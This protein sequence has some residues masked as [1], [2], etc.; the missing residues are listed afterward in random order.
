MP[1]INGTY[2]TRL[3]A[4][5]EESDK[6]LDDFRKARKRFVKEYSGSHYAAGR[7]VVLNLVWQQVRAIL[8]SLLYKRQVRAMVKTR[9]KLADMEA[10]AL[11][12]ALD[13]LFLQIEFLGTLRRACTDAMFGLA[14]VK[15]GMCMMPGSGGYL[16]DQM[17]PFADC[18]DLD[19][20]VIDTEARVREEAVYEGNGYFLPAEFAQQSGIFDAKALASITPYEGEDEGKRTDSVSK[21]PNSRSKELAPR[22][23]FIDLWLPQENALLTLPGDRSAPDVVL[24]EA[25]YQGPETGPYDMLGFHWVPGSVLPVSPVALMYDLHEAV[26]IQARKIVN[27]ANAH[28]KVLIY[29]AA[30][31]EDADR[32]RVASDGSFQA[33]R[34]VDRMKEME[35]GAP[36]KDRYQTAAW[37]LQQFETAGGNPSLQA[38]IETKQPTLGQTQALMQNSQAW[39]G[40]MQAQVHEF[41][42]AV[43]GKL[44]WYIWTAAKQQSFT[45][46]EAGLPTQEYAL[47][48]QGAVGNFA[49][50]RIELDLYSSLADSP[51][52][53]YQRFM[54]YLALVA[55]LAPYAMQ[56][57]ALLDVVSPTQRVA[58]W[59]D[60]PELA[61]LWV[62]AMPMPAGPVTGAP[63]ASGE[64][65]RSASGGQGRS[66][67]QPQGAAA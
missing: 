49:D 19:D 1:N 31:A 66:Q 5:V 62:P 26:N 50:F 59:L 33:V 30:D 42:A 56:Q 43:A 57:G 6:R 37:L 22:Y 7:K 53:R 58:E 24:R 45:K 55:P 29:D 52:A 17:Q 27:E 41:A 46:D 60:L 14:V 44:A 64:A 15:T 4:M 36:A 63:G 3:R 51:Q 48:P 23:R 20:Y 13:E 40:D 8:P 47:D 54:E 34:N 9:N 21:K 38:G 32:L 10:V 35:I 25:Q 2:I 16:H 12:L 11:G 67:R 61:R 65:M 39:L 28:K 18:V